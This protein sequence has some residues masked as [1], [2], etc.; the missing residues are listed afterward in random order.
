ML[1]KS[2]VRGLVKEVC[3]IL[4][5]RPVVFKVLHLSTEWFVLGFFQSCL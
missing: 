2:W 4:F 1:Y 3:R 5:I